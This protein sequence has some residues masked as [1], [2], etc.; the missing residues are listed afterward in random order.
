MNL[1]LLPLFSVVVIFFF[2]STAFSTPLP[3]CV[4]ISSYHKGYEW[5]DGIEA[6]LREV[7]D[8]QC[9][10]VQ[11]DMDKK[12]HREE[13]EILKK[14][15]EVKELIE[16]SKPDVVITSDDNVAKYVI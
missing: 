8:G 2:T 5:S 3:V 1:K 13:S 15:R 12:R 11:F 9:T 14:A 7:L 16:Q 10:F 6:S 4:Y